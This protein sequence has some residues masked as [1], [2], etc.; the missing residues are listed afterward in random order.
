MKDIELFVLVFI[1]SAFSAA[2]FY[3]IGYCEGVQEGLKEDKA[4]E[5]PDKCTCK[6]PDF[7]DKFCTTK[8]DCS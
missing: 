8:A 6:H 1:I 3:W 4:P 5:P 2:M 7:C